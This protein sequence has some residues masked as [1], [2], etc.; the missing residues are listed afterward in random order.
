MITPEFTQP[1]SRRVDRH[2][3]HHEQSYYT[4]Q[5]RMSDA[6]GWEREIPPVSSADLAIATL[7]A[8]AQWY[9]PGRIRAVRK[10]VRTTVET[11]TVELEPDQALALHANGDNHRD[12]ATGTTRTVV[13]PLRAAR[14][15]TQQNKD[16]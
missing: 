16:K 13:R 14:P 1:G 8:H 5:H 7:R 11:Y 15:R 3:D 12:G 9:A 6:D 4:V 2:V 10:V